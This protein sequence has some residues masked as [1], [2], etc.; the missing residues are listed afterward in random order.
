VLGCDKSVQI[1]EMM[2]CFDRNFGIAYRVLKVIIKV[3]F[4]VLAGMNL[5]FRV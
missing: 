4:G 3:L 5:L 1:A 2:Y